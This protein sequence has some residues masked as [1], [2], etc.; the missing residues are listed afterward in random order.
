MLDYQVLRQLVLEYLRESPETQLGSIFDGITKLA[1]KQDIFP[2]KEECDKQNIPFVATSYNN[3]NLSRNDRRNV[4]QIILDLIVER[5]LT[6]GA[7]DQEQ[8]PWLR[9]TEFGHEVANKQF[10]NYYD[11]DGYVEMLE[12]F[13]P[14]IDPVIIQYAMEGLNCFRKRLFFA[15]AVMYGAAAEKTILLLLE[16]I[17]NAETD[18]KKKEN[19]VKLLGRP[20]HS[21]IFFIIQSTIESLIKAKKIPYS[22]HQ[23]SIENLLS[24]FEMIRVQRNEAVHPAVGEVNEIKIILFIQAFPTAIELVYRLINWFSENKI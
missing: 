12:S 14:N 20:S 18:P 23:S 13:A 11:P 1:I 21:E 24:L 17:G 19:I 3:K 4:N 5:V 8:W 10:P 2:S 22:V 9:L 6:I 15:S 7:K 16:S